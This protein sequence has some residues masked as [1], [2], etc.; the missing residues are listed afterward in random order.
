MQQKTQRSVYKITQASLSSWWYNSIGQT[1]EC[2]WQL[3][4]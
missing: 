2:S 3:I 1:D 4:T